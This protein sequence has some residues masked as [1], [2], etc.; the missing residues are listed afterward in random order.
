MNQRNA[1]EYTVDFPKVMMMDRMYGRHLIHISVRLATTSQH[2]ILLHML[3]VIDLYS[4]KQGIASEKLNLI[5]FLCIR[6]FAEHAAGC[7]RSVAF[8]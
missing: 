3:Q 5:F 6:A 4:L 8:D 7:F 2:K 1:D